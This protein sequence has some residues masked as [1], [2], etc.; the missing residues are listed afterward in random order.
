MKHLLKSILVLMALSPLQS[1]AGG[2]E[3]AEPEP[4]VV[5]NPDTQYR[6]DLTV[7]TYNILQLPDVAGDW[8]DAQRLARL[9][10]AIRNMAVQPDVL[11]IQ[12]AMTDAAR[13]ALEGLD[14]IYP[15]ITPVVGLD[16]SG[17]GWD[18]TSGNCSNSPAVV[19][20]GVM[21]LS[22]WPIEEQRQH[23]YQNSQM[24][25]GDY[26]SNKGFAYVRIDKGGF[27]YHVVGT[28]M[29][30]DAGDFA[31]SQQTRMAQLDE[32]RQW[33]D[34]RA[35]SAADPVILTGDFNVEH[36][37]ND[38]LADMLQRSN[39]QISFPDPSIGSY[40][41]LDNLMTQ[42]NAYYY[43]YSQ[44][45]NDTL[46]YVVTRTDYLLPIVSADMQVIR[47]KADDSW[48]WD[49]MENINSTGM[50]SE[51]SDH[52]PVVATFRYH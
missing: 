25:T 42:A 1:L 39:S 20:G 50:H 32:M 9:P 3:P 11:V 40:S 15:F 29:Q 35:I 44:S 5:D 23:I 19:R 27:D 28:H 33:I 2:G 7:M 18:G 17:A 16:C 45:Y 41:A 8:D 48:Y 43:E 24:W 46:D 49:Y 34:N 47:L 37:R 12:E 10:D 22:R 6:S 38:H 26:Y 31:V 13:N 51:L 21:V 4:P 52:Y 30:S 36:S 14:D